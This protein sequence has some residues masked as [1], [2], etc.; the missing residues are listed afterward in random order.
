VARVVMDSRG[1]LVDS[2]GGAIGGPAG[3]RAVR[4]PGAVPDAAAWQLLAQDRHGPVALRRYARASRAQSAVN[5]GQPRAGGF[6]FIRSPKG[7]LRVLAAGTEAPSC[8]RTRLPGGQWEPLGQPGGTPS[9]VD[10]KAWLA[11]ADG[12]MMVRRNAQGIL[13]RGRAPQGRDVSE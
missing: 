3:G 10:V 2:V 1:Y 12:A 13:E 9:V 4:I 7:V 6:A 8:M 5:L 11:R